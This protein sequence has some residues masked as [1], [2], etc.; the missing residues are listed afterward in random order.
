MK[1]AGQTLAMNLWKRAKREAT[2]RFAHEREAAEVLRAEETEDRKHLLSLIEKLQ[3]E[4][5]ALFARAQAADAECERVQG[6]LTKVEN[7]L[8]RFRVEEFWDRVMQ[9]VAELLPYQGAM[10]PAEILPEPRTWNSRPASLDAVLERANDLIFASPPRR[11]IAGLRREYD[12]RQKLDP[13]GPKVTLL[14]LVYQS[15]ADELAAKSFDFS[16]LSI[17]DR[18]AAG[19]RDAVAGLEL[20]PISDPG[21]GRFNYVTLTAPA[22]TAPA[23]GDRP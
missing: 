5:V 23:G 2:L 9:E 19:G 8:E 6:R 15:G 20:L 3:A 10:T 22:I 17:R 1:T 18:W 21:S 12:L 16:R 14:H 4:S 7:Q 13:G 11:A